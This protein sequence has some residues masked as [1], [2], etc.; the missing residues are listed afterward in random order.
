MNLPP[1]WRTLTLWVFRWLRLVVALVLAVPFGGAASQADFIHRISAESREV[2]LT[3]AAGLFIDPSG[4]LS[5]EQVAALAEAGAMQRVTRVQFGGGTTRAIWVKLD[6][7]SDPSASTDWLLSV[8][9]PFLHRV[10][11]FIRAG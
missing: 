4:T 6:I 10:R 1:A 2:E 5:V 11:V 3:T 8:G 9:P 7:A